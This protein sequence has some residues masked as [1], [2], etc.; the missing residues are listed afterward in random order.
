MSKT[1]VR[2][3][4]LVRVDWDV[5]VYEDGKPLVT[6][7]PLRDI[8]MVERTASILFRCGHMTAAADLLDKA[9]EILEEASAS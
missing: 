4:T 3:I 1:A 9:A 7:S 2:E 6:I 5:I 8:E